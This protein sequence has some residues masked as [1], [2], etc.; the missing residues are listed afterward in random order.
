MPMKLNV[1]DVVKLKKKHPCGGY[2][3][4][5]LRTGADFRIKCTTC[6]RQ[7]WLPRSEVERRITK[8]IYQVEDENSD[9]Q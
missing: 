3:W 2:D 1:G 7:V 5:I 8:I 9:K 4:E 6:S